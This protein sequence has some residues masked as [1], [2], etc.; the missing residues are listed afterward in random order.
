MLE[1]WTTIRYR[2]GYASSPEERG[3]S[4]EMT[5]WNDRRSRVAFMERPRASMV[6]FEGLLADWVLPELFVHL[7]AVGFPQLPP[8]A[9]A[10][11][12]RVGLLSIASAKGVHQSWIFPGQRMRLPPLERSMQILEGVA[13]A[14]SKGGLAAYRALDRPALV[15]N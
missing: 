3:G 6:V 1:T 5:L 12:I 7:R 11:G 13:Y 14:L 4:V 10:P 8:H 9:G 15:E 2:E